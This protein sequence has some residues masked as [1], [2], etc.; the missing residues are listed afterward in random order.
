[1]SIHNSGESIERFSMGK[2]EGDELIEF[3]G[4]LLHCDECQQEVRGL[5]LFWDPL[6]RAAPA[7]AHPVTVAE[8]PGRKGTYQ[9]VQ[10]VLSRDAMQDI[11]IL[12]RA[13]HNRLY[14]LF[15]RDF[16]VFAGD[17]AEQLRQLT[18]DI[19][20]KADDLGA[21]KCLEWLRAMTSRAVGVSRRR[22]IVIEGHAAKKLR[23]LYAKHVRPHVLPFRTHLP[24]YSLEAAAGEFGRQ[25]SV[26]PE[27]WVEVQ[28]NMPLSDDMFVVHVEGH[29]MEPL[30]PAASLC[31]FRYK[32]AGSWDGK[33][34][35]IQQYGVSGG[36]R[37]TVKMCRVSKNVDPD[38]PGNKAVLHERV[39]LESIN[40]GYE[41]WDVPINAKIR[42]LGEF[43]FVV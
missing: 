35:L 40:H 27:G 12:L 8:P 28:T 42:A 11:G 31:A 16:E 36:C 13:Q 21:Q 20:E 26:E 18:S 30:I 14:T 1:M 19:S 2:L 33:V 24:Q 25:M 3:R 4:H 32:L 7:P 23:E 9:I 37:Y 5:D 43:L 22:R 17:Q 39:T 29:S 34:L 38:P 15:R 41:S 6:Q 10:A